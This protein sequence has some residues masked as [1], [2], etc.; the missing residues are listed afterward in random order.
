MYQAFC[1]S[2]QAVVVY[3]ILDYVCDP[4]ETSGVGL[5]FALFTTEF[6]KTSMISLQ[7]A[8]TLHTAIRL[9]GALCS[10]GFQK[11]TSLRVLGDM[12]NGEVKTGLHTQ[13]IH[14][15][16]TAVKSGLVKV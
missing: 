6:L 12:S 9:K 5:A 14:F 8:L 11:V 2:L 1:L 3:K 7:W 10:L 13:R 16:C 4:G 15:T